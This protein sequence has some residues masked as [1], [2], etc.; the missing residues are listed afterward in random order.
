M[1]KFSVCAVDQNL[2]SD[3]PFPLRGKTYTE[4]ADI[5]AKLGYDGIELQIQ[6][7]KEYNGAK[8]KRIFD[9]HGIHVSAV[10]TGLAYL[11]EG[12]SMTHP[13]PT[14]REKTVQRLKRQL[15]LAKELDTG[16]LVGFL[17]G[18][19]LD[20]SAREYEAIL[21]ESVQKVLD[22]AEEIEA[23]F[24]FEQINH[25]DG[26][27]Y[28]STDRTM[29]FLESFNSKWLQFNGDTYHME[30]DDTDI[31]KAIIRSLGKLTLFHVSDVGR[32]LPDDKHFD[33]QTAARTLIDSNYDKW[34]TIEC[35][36][37]P[38][39]LTCCKKGLEYMHRLFGISHP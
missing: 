5:A 35:V 2:P 16:I 39:S 17:R 24:I 25:K 34:V 33:F 20:R 21:S 13:D 30:L 14:I 29:E 22:Y 11:Y 19:Q 10:T 9:D 7:P 18:R 4:C 26:D 27:I 6:D 38:D 23:P 15:D 12:M 31:Q 3:K 28:C 32:L 1:M 36:P 37:L 8:M